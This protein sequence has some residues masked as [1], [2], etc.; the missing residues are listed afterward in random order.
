MFSQVANSS[1]KENNL[2]TSKSDNFTPV[3][4]RCFFV[5][6][7]SLYKVIMEGGEN[8]MLQVLI[9]RITDIS[10][11]KNTSFITLKT[12]K[13]EVFICCFAGHNGFCET[14]V[15]GD[16]VTLHGHQ[17]PVEGMFQVKTLIM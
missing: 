4:S 1:Q 12:V 11:Q 15:K 9:G 16:A 6:N 2:I 10:I 8:N 3:N 7:T 14:L 17:G 13:E 5:N